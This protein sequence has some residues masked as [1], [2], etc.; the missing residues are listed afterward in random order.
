MVRITRCLGS[1]RVAKNVDAIAVSSGQPP[2]L[3][4]LCLFT[5]SLLPVCVFCCVNRCYNRSAEIVRMEQARV[6]AMHADATK[7]ETLRALGFGLHVE[8][9]SF[10][11]YTRSAAMIFIA[12][13]K[14]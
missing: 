10:C 7:L 5:V 6:E 4:Y 9:G 8:V 11:I 2:F 13:W 1:T 14:R 3:V 12:T